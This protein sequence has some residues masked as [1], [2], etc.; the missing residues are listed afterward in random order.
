MRMGQT[1]VP[2]SQR[3][4]FGTGISQSAAKG[5]TFI[6]KPNAPKT[7]VNSSKG[8]VSRRNTLFYSYFL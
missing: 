8:T 7:P 1:G 5:D 3:S 6:P 2:L 4:G